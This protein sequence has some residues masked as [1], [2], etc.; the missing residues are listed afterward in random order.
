MTRCLGPGAPPLP[1]L[2]FA[3]SPASDAGQTVLRY[4]DAWR[5]GRDSVTTPH[6]ST[7]THPSFPASRTPFFRVFSSLLVLYS[8]SLAVSYKSLSR[9]VFSQSASFSPE[10][11]PTIHPPST[12]SISTATVILLQSY[13]HPPSSLPLFSSLL[14]FSSHSIS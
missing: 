8:S 12:Q 2:W 3:A 4:K 6:P 7:H 11:S 9:P 10:S 14:L 1:V 5:A 13:S